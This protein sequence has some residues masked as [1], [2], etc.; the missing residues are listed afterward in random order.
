M[1]LLQV[2][3]DRELLGKI[4]PAMDREF[5]YWM[6]NRTTNVEIEGKSYQLAHYDVEVDGPRPGNRDNFLNWTPEAGVEAKWRLG[7]KLTE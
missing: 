5:S 2:T 1:D 4:I 6:A 7:A 3:S